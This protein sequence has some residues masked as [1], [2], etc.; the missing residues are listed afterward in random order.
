MKKNPTSWGDCEALDGECP[1]QPDPECLGCL[2]G[3][4]DIEINT[5]GRFLEEQR[6]QLLAA[7][8]SRQTVGDLIDAFRG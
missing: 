6:A 3:L 7:G 2:L 8:L 1:A 4:S 5:F